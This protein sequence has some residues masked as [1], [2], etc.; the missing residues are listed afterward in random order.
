MP[1]PCAS[2]RALMVDRVTEHM[3]PPHVDVLLVVEPE[4]PRTYSRRERAAWFASRPGRRRR[5]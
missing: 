5:R 1:N 4:R 2:A 3:L